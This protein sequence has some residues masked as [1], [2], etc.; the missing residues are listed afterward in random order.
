MD[1]LANRKG[2]AGLESASQGTVPAGREPTPGA[3]L[4]ALARAELETAV[5]AKKHRYRVYESLQNLNEVIGTQYGDRVLYELIQ[6]AHDAHDPGEQGR[7]SIR[8][9]VQ[10]GTE[11][12]LFIANCGTGF[13]MEEDVEAI[14]NLAISAKEI[15][16]GIGNKGL[17]FRSIEALTDDVRIYSQ[18]KAQQSERFDGYCFRF[19]NAEE[20]E[21][22]LHSNGVETEIAKE[23]S[24]TLPRFLIPRPLYEQSD[25]IAAFAR[26]GYAT[27]IV[28]PLRSSQAV[29]LATQ[30]VHALADP[31]APLLLFLER[32]GE[33]RIEMQ[34]PDQ[35]PFLRLLRRRQISMGEIPK[36]PGCGMYAVDV[37]EGRR[38]L[39]VRREVDKERVL[40]SVRRS[41]PKAPQL[42]RWLKW[43]GQPVVSVAVGLFPESVI[44]GRLYNFLPMGKDALAPLMGYLDAPFF[45]D[46]DRRNA[47]LELPLNETLMEA[48]A[49][50]SAAAALSIVECGGSVP[51][52]AVFDLITWTGDQAGKLD[53]ALKGAGSSLREARV[54]PSIAIEGLGAWSSLSEVSLWPE[55]AFSVL[56]AR[57]VARYVGAQLVSPD[58]DDRRVR[59]LKEAAAR[60]YRSLS[61]TAQRLAAWAEAFARSLADRKVG[62]RTWSRF[63]D[64]LERVFAAAGADLDAL[65]QKSIFYD[66][67]GKLRPA[68]GHGGISKARIYVRS[69]ASKGKRTDEGIPLP[70]STLVRRYRFLDERITFRRETLGAFIAADLI[71]E[72]DP[73]EALAGLKSALGGSANDK[74]RQEALLWSFQV[75]RAAGSTVEDEL[76]DAELYVPT[77]SGWQPAAAAAFS[78]SWTM[79]GRTLE[80][81]LVE[82][83]EVS[84]DCRRT[85][86]LL[87][88]GHHVWPDSSDATKRQWVRFLELIGVAAG[89]RPI[90]GRLTRKGWPAYMW[91]IL[92]HSGKSSE[93]P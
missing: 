52:H 81:Y 80:N 87:L 41:I 14:R 32:I 31:E 89:L 44:K 63:Y 69:E 19:A 48:A 54:I 35:V 2:D 79:V 18:E 4:D 61:P 83:A 92:L 90:P 37:G 71:R 30:Q 42:K 72:Y 76:R 25:D 45:A 6:N 5:N 20:V 55:G 74:R 56:S 23:V 49:E 85:R 77:L 82:A 53:D 67:S 65:T 36:L 47:D 7:I 17:G 24:R 91:G 26:S 75:W 10:S 28:A 11:G 34:S 39:V 40:E 73:T 57:E 38:F 1:I 70:P 58:L 68:G 21:A 62:P 60:A 12:C 59:R 9:I 66:R 27:V 64:E 13:R 33:V 78:S 16:E 51:P 8:L 88:V 50:A 3:K 15:G 46:I 43:K 86:E 93:G 84:V 22:Q 29:D